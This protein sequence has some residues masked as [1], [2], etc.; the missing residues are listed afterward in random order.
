MADYIFLIGPGGAGKSTVGKILSATPGYNLIDLD[1]EFCERIMNKA[2]NRQSQ[3][4]PCTVT[5]LKPPAVD[6]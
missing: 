4:R 1:D 3:S 5:R 6:W 2:I